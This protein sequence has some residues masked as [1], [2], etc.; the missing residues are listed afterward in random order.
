MTVGQV[1]RLTRDAIAEIVRQLPDAPPPPVGDDEHRRHP[2]WP[3]HGTIELRPMFSR[4]TESVTGAVRNISEGGL[5]MSSSH[6]FEPD[7]IVEIVVQLPHA[8]FSTKA[9]VRYC[10]KVRDE[11]MTGLAFIFEG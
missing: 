8:V 6:Y 4:Q 9:C 3:S 1:P 5:G 11:H 7:S 10:K 2:R